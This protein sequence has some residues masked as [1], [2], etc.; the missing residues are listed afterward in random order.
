MLRAVSIPTNLEPERFLPL[1]KQC[2][3]IFN[4]HVDWALANHTYNKSKAHDALYAPLRQLYP[5]I[6]SAFVQAVRDTA[7]EA[8]KATKFERCPHKRPTSSLRYD[9]R[10]MTLRGYQLTLSCI[11]GR[12]KTILSVPDYFR[13][14]FETWDFKGA[15]LTYKRH[16]R[17]LWVQLVFESP[18][19]ALREKGH[20]QGI[21]RGLYHLAVTSDGQTHSNTKVRSV[22][23]RY[24]YN[25]RALQ[26]K[27]TRSAKRRLKAM[28]GR[29][30]RFSK[31]VNH[32]VTKQIVNQP[33]VTTFVLEDLSGIRN[34]RRGKKMNKWLGS[35]PFYQFEMFLAYKA[36][37]LGKEVVFVD[38]RYTSQKCSQCG[39]KYKGNRHGS[40]FYCVRCGFRA[41]A[42]V[43]AA[44]N[45]RDTYLLSTAER[46]VEQAAVSQ[47]QVTSVLGESPTSV[48]SHRA[49]PAGA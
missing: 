21:D 2:A 8:V 22:Q 39:H 14:I 45:V 36:E 49:C 12:A 44:I 1:M 9:K 31:N 43:N 40:R 25:R 47:P 24:L 37:A 19:P 11:G 32:V 27:G 20:T 5:D 18:T 23:R 29:E 38:P 6:P 48:T 10:T 41:H 28:S 17:Q 46:S 30:Q 15:T 4:T 34:K 35:W 13:E 3:G 16:K 33:D 26:A 42:D 7:M